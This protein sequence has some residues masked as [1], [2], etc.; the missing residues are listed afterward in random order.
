M[1]YESNIVKKPWGYEYLAYENEKVA[2]WMLYIAQGQR[3]SMHCHP[4]K[5][6]G[7][8]I[9]NGNAEVSFL[10]NTLIAPMGMKVMIRKG[11]FHSTKSLHPE[12]SWV[13]EIETPVD[14]H[15]LVRFKDSYGREG[16]PYEDHSHEAPKD[17]DCVW[18]EDPSPGATNTYTL[19]NAA[20]I[21]SINVENIEFF[22]E[23]ADDVNV[24]FLRGG[25]RTDYGIN[26]A[27]AG[28]IVTG[29][30]IK[31]LINV[32]RSL[33]EQTTIMISEPICRHRSEP[34]C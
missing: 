28:D 24:V 9:L 12:G 22:D 8:M 21:K 33:D 16:K 5:T 27:G 23:L 7:L 1:A 34:T 20:T 14:K 3:T 15:D 25:I 29:K 10:S 13:M 11:L 31:K 18:I 30:V 4:N 6:T 26:V 17:Q 2:L 19:A 32:F